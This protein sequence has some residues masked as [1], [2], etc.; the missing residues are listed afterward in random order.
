MHAQPQ[1]RNSPL[2]PAVPSIRPGVGAAPLA[3]AQQQASQK[4]GAKDLSHVPCKFFRANSC[5]AGKSCPFSHDL[6]TPGTSKPICQWFAKGNCKFGHKCALAHVLS[7]QPMSFDR[8]NKRAAQQALREAQAN[9][10]DTG[11]VTATNVTAQQAQ[12]APPNGNGL[13]Q[14][15]RQAVDFGGNGEY[16]QLAYRVNSG[17]PGPAS[18]GG[19]SDFEAVFGSPDS[20]GHRTPASSPGLQHRNL[21]GS[22]VPHSPLSFATLS[23]GPTATFIAPVSSGLSH[24]LSSAPN[25]R[26]SVAA[27]AMLSEQARRLSSTS[28][29]TNEQLSPPRMAALSRARLSFNGA[30]AATDLPSSPPLAVPGT[31]SATGPA[32]I[33]GTSPF[34]GSRGLFIPSSYD[35]NEDAFPRSPPARYSGLPEMARSTSNGGWT[36]AGLAA[37][38][39]AIADDDEDEGDD[40]FDEAFL[41][42]SLNDLLTPEEMRRRTMRANSHSQTNGLHGPSSLAKDSTFL[43]SPPSNHV[44]LNSQSVPAD[45]FLSHGFPGVPASSSPSL[46]IPTP[47]PIGARSATSAAAFSPSSG[48]AN[49]SNFGALSSSVEGH[50]PSALPYEPTLPTRSLLSQSRTAASVT[51]TTSAGASPNLSSS[52]STFEG[53]GGAFPSATGLLSAT[54]RGGNPHVNGNGQ[55]T[56]RA[57]SSARPSILSAGIYSASFN[58]AASLHHHHHHLPSSS[59]IASSLLPPSNNNNG[60]PRYPQTGLSP[61]TNASL[62]LPGSSLPGGLAAGLSRLHLVPPAHTGETPPSSYA[63][64]AASPPNGR[65]GLAQG[66]ALARRMSTKTRE[67][68]DVNGAGGEGGGEN[69]LLLPRPPVPLRTHTGASEGVV[70]S[71]ASAVGEDDGGEEGEMIQ[72]DLET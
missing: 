52:A 57:D 16:A 62:A 19:T 36:L 23:Q 60:G 25:G 72:F 12:Y 48:F 26:S 13:V 14:T 10:Q 9:G 6:S 3:T 42:S 5:T 56:L 44:Y 51:S 63:A 61:N 32:A 43:S 58:D 31:P 45:L 28:N 17:A 47:P 15:L 2:P 11:L 49:G 24:H 38:E 1:H 22:A 7:G 68:E 40:G 4:K 67:G 41:P 29:S 55:D 69:V 8:K 27:Q 50:N 21:P 35:S 39:Q 46:V 37:A 33:F 66:S 71:G 30:S 54:L 70:S 65:A 64:A 34:S 53:P 18:N 59:H 20:L